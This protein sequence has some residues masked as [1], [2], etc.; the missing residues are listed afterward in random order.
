MIGIFRQKQKKKAMLAQ[1]ET[2]HGRMVRAVEAF[3]RVIKLIFNMLV[4]VETTNT[5]KSCDIK[6]VKILLII[7]LYRK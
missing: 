7:N 5:F 6:Q 1:A 2:E 3:M 4:I